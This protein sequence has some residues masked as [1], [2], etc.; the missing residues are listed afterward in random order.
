MKQ[1]IIGV[2]KPF[3]N[4]E[5]ELEMKQRYS[6]NLTLSRNENLQDRRVDVNS[7][8]P[9][10]T[11]YNTSNLNGGGFG[12]SLIENS[13]TVK[14]FRHTIP[15]DKITSVVNYNDNVSLH[16]SGDLFLSNDEIDAK[17]DV[18]QDKIITLLPDSKE[19]IQEETFVTEHDDAIKFQLSNYKQILS[20]GPNTIQSKED[21]EIS[22]FLN[23][24]EN[25]S[26]SIVHKKVIIE[27]SDA[28]RNISRNST[29]IE[30]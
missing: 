2:A 23:I 6:N 10:Y 26:D 25:Y 4:T 29:F 13:A 28:K 21:N 5:I 3:L 24:T 19:I 18:S 15:V 14:P 27:Y 20:T 12:S 17:S 16:Y 7:Q 22:L 1:N 9:V 11:S 8:Q 30:V